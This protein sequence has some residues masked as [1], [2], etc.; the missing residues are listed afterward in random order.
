MMNTRQKIAAG[1]GN[2]HGDKTGKAWNGSIP[3]S[4]DTTS[5]AFVQEKSAP[6]LTK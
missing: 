4:H 5:T 3:V 6:R 2:T 1:G